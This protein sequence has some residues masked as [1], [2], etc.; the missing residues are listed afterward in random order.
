MRHIVVA[1]DDDEL[2][3]LV[4]AALRRRGYIVASVR[5]GASLVSHVRECKER[6]RTPNLI[7]T[8]V[9]MPGID[10]LEALQKVREMGVH[11]PAVVVTA[12]GT[13]AVR[14][15]AAAIGNTTLLDKPFTLHR[16]H[17]QLLRQLGDAAKVDAPR[18]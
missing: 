3:R 15:R 7:V 5:D 12:Y 18:L 6:G 14:N 10:G 1:D 16:L 9:Q 13:R 2:R 8:D 17:D 4:S 11:V